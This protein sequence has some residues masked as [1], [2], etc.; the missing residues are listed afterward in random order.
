[1]EHYLIRIEERLRRDRD[2]TVLSD[3][4]GDSFTGGRLAGEL[5]RLHR[6]FRRAGLAPGDR[7]AIAARNSAR[8]AAVFLAANTYRAVAVPILCDFT[9]ADIASLAEHAGCL[10]L[11]TER[12]IWDRMPAEAVPALKGV[13]A[14]EDFSL[15]RAADAVFGRAFAQFAEEPAEAPRDGRE[16]PLFPE[17]PPLDELM[18]INYTSGTTGRPKGIMLTGRN[19]SSNIA[20]ALARIP[21]PAG[22]ASISMLPLAHM[23]GLA[24]E[25]LYP[26]CGGS[27]VTFL[28]VA[29]S[30][31]VLLA[32][33]AAVRPYILITVPLVMEKIVKGRVMPLLERPA[34]RVLT[35]IPGLR[36][37]VYNRIRRG[38]L[39]SFGGRV[40]TLVMGG[41]PLSEG[42]ERILRTARIPYTVGY[43]MTECAPL[44]AYED[45]HAF[46][47]RSCGRVVT[48]LEIRVASPDPERM[49][50]E[51]Q[52]RG[53]NVMQGYYRDPE[54]TAAAFTEDGWLRTGDLGIIDRAGNIFIRGRSKCMILSSNGQN[55]YPEEI[56][57]RLN[58]MP[59]IAE[60]LVVER[61]GL[62]VALVA[63]QNTPAADAGAK[64]GAKPGAES[65]SSAV[66]GAGIEPTAEAVARSLEET[67]SRL[68]ALLPAYSRIARIEVLPDGFAHTP[69][70]SIRRFLYT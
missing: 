19:L 7:I 28:G 46:A 9:P 47:P 38:I 10:L 61:D 2:R 31:T 13:V 70:Q 66:P 59:G 18:I 21:V 12:R 51:L 69:K 58:L 6:L 50:G 53:E 42:V 15:L 11:F 36:R 54:A 5:L 20:F 48:G 14:V 33:F 67:R 24:F 56:E 65:G 43:G 4:R 57:A 25:F 49:V 26:L 3:Y 40:G 63:L 68:N 23:Y 64:S 32:A 52:V 55:I 17:I 39:A 45:W 27:C 62:L 8:W 1:M 30:P 60:S 35:A 34:I 41:A 37:L 29:P 16:E 22:A 44:V